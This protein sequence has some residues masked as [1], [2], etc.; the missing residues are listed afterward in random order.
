MRNF[1]VFSLQKKKKNVKLRLPKCRSMARHNFFR[2]T[3]IYSVCLKK[4]YV[5]TRFVF[6]INVFDVLP[7]TENIVLYISRLNM[8]QN[9]GFGNENN[10]NCKTFSN[11]VF[12]PFVEI[13]FCYFFF[14]YLVASVY[15]YIIVSYRIF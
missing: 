11:F 14:F 9:V 4:N 7:S 2:L 12:F 13:L 8:V 3:C 10:N 6:E 5:P 1:L 15:I